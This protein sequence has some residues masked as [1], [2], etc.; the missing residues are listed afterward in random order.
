MLRKN[1]NIVAE[2]AYDVWGKVISATSITDAYT[3]V[4]TANPI[5]YRGYTYDSDTG[6]YYLQTRYYAPEIGRFII[7]DELD[8]QPPIKV[9]EYNLFAYCINNPVNFNDISG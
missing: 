9:T 5:R 6:L 2:Y 7:A 4:M 3:D 8:F 1:G